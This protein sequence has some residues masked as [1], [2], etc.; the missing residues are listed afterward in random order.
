VKHPSQTSAFFKNGIDLQWL[1]EF[2]SF[3]E[4]QMGFVFL[5]TALS[6]LQKANVVPTTLSAISF[7]DIRRD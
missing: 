1:T 2:N 7:R 5:Q 6:D 3:G 4:N